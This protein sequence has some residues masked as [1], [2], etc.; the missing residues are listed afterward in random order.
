MGEA[1]GFQTFAPSAFY[2]GQLR[3]CL[4]SSV[5]RATPS[6]AFPCALSWPILLH[7]FRQQIARCG[8]LLQFTQQ[9]HAIAALQY[10]VRAGI[11]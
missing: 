7:P 2:C 6:P 9:Q 8:Q 4:P 5:L 1:E 11:D 3:L 10:F